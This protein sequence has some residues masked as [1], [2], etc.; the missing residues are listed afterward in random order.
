MLWLV[1]EFTIRVLGRLTLARL[2][3]LSGRSVSDTEAFALTALLVCPALVIL[4]AV[5]YRRMRRDGIGWPELQYRWSS[6]TLPAG[7]AGGG[8]VL[9]LMLLAG[10]LDSV[11]FPAPLDER[12]VLG[13]FSSAGRT[14]TAALLFG[15]GILAPL[16]EEFAW[17][18]YIQTRLTAGWSARP[19]W[20]VTSLLFASKHIIVDRSMQRSASLIVGALALGYIGR[21]WGTAASTLAH[22]IPNSV[23]TV[24]IF[25]LASME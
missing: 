6:S 18:G 5:F 21:R 3:T 8:A 4:G 13:L 22:M 10:G 17:R 16:V 20:I 19:A 15:N 12:A 24:L 1:L 14:T 23:I 11:L 2:A 9:G 25:M 7:L